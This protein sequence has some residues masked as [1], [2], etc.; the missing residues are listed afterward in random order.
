[1]SFAL[2]S[3]RLV[4]KVKDTITRILPPPQQMYC[5][6]VCP[7]GT[8]RGQ[9]VGAAQSKII[10]LGSGLGAISGGMIAEER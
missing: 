4:E 6:D 3:L 1:M 7:N 2:A 5:R 8:R 9:L 10:A